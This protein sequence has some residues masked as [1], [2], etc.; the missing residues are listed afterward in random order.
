MKVKSALKQSKGQSKF[1]GIALALLLPL[2][3]FFPNTPMKIVTGVVAF[4]FL[5]EFT[6]VVSITR[7]SRVNPEYL[8][9]KIV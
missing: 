4:A 3:L 8:E 9:E 7:K 1:F 6:N 2:L 5:M